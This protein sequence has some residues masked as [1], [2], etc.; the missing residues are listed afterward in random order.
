MLSEPKELSLKLKK[1]K[2]Q[3]SAEIEKNSRASCRGEESFQKHHRV[4]IVLN[5]VNWFVSTFFS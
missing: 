5:V 1:K 4:W 3:A 2:K